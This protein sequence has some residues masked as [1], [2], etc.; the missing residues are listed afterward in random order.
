MGSYTI[1][2]QFILRGFSAANEKP[3]LY[4]SPRSMIEM[5]HKNFFK[6]VGDYSFKIWNDER[7]QAFKEQFEKDFLE[8]FYMK[9]INFFTADAFILQ[10]GSFLRRKMPVYCQHWR[11]I[12]DEMYTTESGKVK[13]S[14]KGSTANKDNKQT[15][16]WGKSTTDS[17]STTVLKAA[18]SD[19]PQTLLNI[20]LDSIDYATEAS[21]SESN[22]KSTS[23]TNSEDHSTAVGNATGT[24]ENS[25]VTDNYGRSKDVF[26]IYDEWIKSGYDLFTPLFKEAM[27]EQLFLIFN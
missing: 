19:L 3:E 20:D 14:S 10:L 15:D 4:V 8:Y 18:K 24:T 16:S 6:A 1:E 13:G 26:D 27:N 17:E 12:L 23:T 9:E 11:V 7:D 2:L 5:T 25:N 22:D 21:K